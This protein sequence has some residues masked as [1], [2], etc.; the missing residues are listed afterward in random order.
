M[1]ANMAKFVGILKRCLLL[2]EMF[3]Q[4]EELTILFLGFTVRKHVL[5]F[6]FLEFSKFL[7]LNT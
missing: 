2:L 7:R 4:L 5:S 3:Y 6:L 1:P